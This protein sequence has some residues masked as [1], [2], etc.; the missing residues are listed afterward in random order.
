MKEGCLF[1]YQVDIYKMGM[2]GGVLFV[3]LESF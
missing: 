1:V 3:P 2:S